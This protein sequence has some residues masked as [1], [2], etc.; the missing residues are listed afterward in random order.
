MEGSYLLAG[1]NRGFRALRWYAQGVMGADAYQK[2]LQHM[3]RVHPDQ[4]PMDERAF[5]RDLYAWQ[6]RNP[7]GRCC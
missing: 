4:A 7:Q 1:V 2:Y 6:S 5:W 3:A